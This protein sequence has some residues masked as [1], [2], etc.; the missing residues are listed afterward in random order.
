MSESLAAALANMRTAVAEARFPLAVPSAAEAESA[1][2]RIGKQLDDYL[3]PR[4]R[5]LDA[6]L[7][8]VVGG[9]T[10]AGKSTLVNSIVQ[11]PVS[12]ASVLRPTTRSPVLVSNPADTGW[13]TERHILPG[14][15][16]A[17]AAKT[18]DYTLQ[19]ISAPALQPGLALLD[20]PD[21]DSVVDANRE[22]AAQL[23]AAAD[24]WLF[25][26]TAARYADAVPWRM[27]KIARDRGTVLALVLDRVPDGAEEEITAHLRE[28]L[29]EQGLTDTGMFVIP[30]TTVDGSGLLPDPYVTPIRDYLTNLAGDASARAEVVRATV[31]GAIRSA[32][33]DVDTLAQAADQQ[34]QAWNELDR[35][36]TTI[37]NEASAGTAHAVADGALLRGEVLARWQEFVGTGDLMKTLQVQMGRLRDRVAAAVTG[38]PPPGKELK[39]AITSRLSALIEETATSASERTAGRWREMPAGAPLV[40]SALERPGPNLKERSERL[41]RD[42]QRGLLELVKEQG[43]KKRRMARVTAYTVNATGLIVMIAVFAS[44]AF[45]PTGAELGVAAGTSVAAQKVLEAIFGDEAMRQLAR[46]AR[47][48]LLARINALLNYEAGRFH[49]VRENVALLPDLPERL[50]IASQSVAH[51]I[52]TMKVPGAVAAGPR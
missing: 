28:M 45:I 6:P 18:N 14:L 33:I 10:G 51:T 42:W 50:R 43:S 13:F 37:Y 9:S 46:T 30:E 47:D 52:D 39:N 48:D 31:Q 32:V 11:A 35:A 3:L 25:V 20:A 29:A 21:I 24:L 36:V 1:A 38:K 22:L 7:L 12:S 40:T 44:T 23:L 15:N 17:V 4:I 27:L 49:A 41:V 2:E 8:V 34:I 19:V 16:R 26:T 5:R